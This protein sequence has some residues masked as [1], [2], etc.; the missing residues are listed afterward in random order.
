M[1]AV[2]T[3]ICFRRAILGR[4]DKI[5][6]RNSGVRSTWLNGNVTPTFYYYSLSLYSLYMLGYFYHLDQYDL[7]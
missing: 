2:S 6:I 7:D 1:C 4:V 3:E 5:T